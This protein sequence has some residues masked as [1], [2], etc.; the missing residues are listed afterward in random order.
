MPRL[1][2]LVAESRLRNRLREALAAT[3]SPFVSVEF[4]DRPANLI[5]T[6]ISIGG[7]PDRLEE[8]SSETEQVLVDIRS[9]GPTAD[10]LATAQEQLTREYELVSNPFWVETMLFYAEYP[11]EDPADVFRRISI[12]ADTTSDDLLEIA[13]IAWP[14]GQYIEVLLV[15]ET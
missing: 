9:S 12:V 11:N 7:D 13:T 1:L 8:I 3:Y 4:F 5:E 14:P 10:E 2:E 15:P 6:Y